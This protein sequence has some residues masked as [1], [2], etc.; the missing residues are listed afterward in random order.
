MEITVLTEKVGLLVKFNNLTQAPGNSTYLWGF[1]DDLNSTSTEKSPTHT[2]TDTGIYPV[3]LTITNSDNTTQ[4]FSQN[5]LVSDKVT[6][7]LSDS[8][9]V[10]INQLIPEGLDLDFSTKRFYIDKWQLYLQPL[11]NHEVEIAKYNNELYFEALENQ[12]IMELSAFDFLN[13]YFNK[14]LTNN[15]V[16]SSESNLKKIVTGPT[17]AEYFDNSEKQ[18]IIFEAATK[19]LQKNGLIDNMRMNICMLAERLSI[20]LPF[21]KEVTNKIS[22]TKVNQRTSDLYEGPNPSYPLNN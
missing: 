4:T 3:T 7:T 15:N 6:T 21:C 12:L 14:I 18:K 22:V 10:L 9:Y 20:Y 16:V 5:V 1:G 17:E 13:N 2:Y 19:A 8:I 11:V